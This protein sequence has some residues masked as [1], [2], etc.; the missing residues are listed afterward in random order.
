MNGLYKDI[1]NSIDFEAWFE[2]V[3]ATELII[4]NDC[5]IPLKA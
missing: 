1:K 3:L 2:N 5:L 4:N